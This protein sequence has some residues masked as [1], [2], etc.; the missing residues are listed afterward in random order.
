MRRA[1]IAERSAVVISTG[2]GGTST[3]DQTARRLYAEKNPRLHPM[4]IVHVMP[5]APAS[6][7]AL[8]SGLRGPAFAETSACASSDH[9][10]GQ[11][12]RWPG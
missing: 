3:Q 9:A 10:I 6:Q 7:I 2:I 12:L 1:G 4:A 5:V 8:E 11:A